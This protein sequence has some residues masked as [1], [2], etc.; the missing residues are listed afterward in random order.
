MGDEGGFAPN[1]QE[2][3]EAVHLLMEAIEKAGHLG[4]IKL[5]MDVAASEFFV[6][7][8]NK[9]D[10]DFKNPKNDKSQQITPEQLQDFYKNLVGKYPIISIEDP[11]DQDDWAAYKSLTQL[12]GDKVQIVGDD[13]LVT[14]PIRVQKA[15]DEKACNALLLKVNQIGT[16]TESIEAVLLSQKNKFGVMTSH[17]SGETEDNFIGDLAIGLATG[18]I[19]TGAPCRSDRNAKYN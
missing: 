7:E 1:I 16:L 9:Y 6:P 12:I 14:N 8:G 19:K 10:L 17:R 11:F 15:I 5:G 2:N 4:K 13:L 3:E 18:E